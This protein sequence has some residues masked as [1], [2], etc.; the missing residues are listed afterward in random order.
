MALNDF[1][2]N[3]D[4]LV[5]EY[6][7]RR[8][9]I[10]EEEVEDLVKCLALYL[11][12]ETKNQ[13]KYAFRF[14]FLGVMYR[15]LNDEIREGLTS[16]TKNVRFNKIITDIFYNNTIDNLHKNPLIEEDMLNRR[17]RGKTK[18]ELQDF[19]NNSED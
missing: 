17:Y 11:K 1:F 9:Y 6:A 8:K 18:E 15:K 19:Q 3:K 10:S 12:R 5:K 14:P 16:R 13:E 7:S 2:Y 4:D